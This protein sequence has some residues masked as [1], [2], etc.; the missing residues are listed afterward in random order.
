MIEEMI[1]STR[2]ASPTPDIVNDTSKLLHAYAALEEV[3]IS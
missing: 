2:L 3:I 1:P